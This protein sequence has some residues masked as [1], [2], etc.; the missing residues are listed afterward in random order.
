LEFNFYLNQL[1]LKQVNTVDELVAKLAEAG[2]TGV[3]A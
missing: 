3:K 2:I 1:M